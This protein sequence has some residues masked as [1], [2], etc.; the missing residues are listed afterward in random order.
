MS[1]PITGRREPAF[2][3]VRQAFAANFTERGEVGAGVCVV[4]EGATVVDLGV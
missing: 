1:A 2:A 4:V 3:G